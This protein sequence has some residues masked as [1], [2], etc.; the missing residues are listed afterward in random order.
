MT[1]HLKGSNDSICLVPI[2]CILFLKK[3]KESGLG[4]TYLSFSYEW[5]AKG[6]VMSIVNHKYLSSSLFFLLSSN[7]N[8]KNSHH[9]SN[10]NC[11]DLFRDTVYKHTFFHLKLATNKKLNHLI[12]ITVKKITPRQ[13]TFHSFIQHFFFRSVAARF[14]TY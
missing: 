13:I 7:N 14:K 9:R 8:K 4:P 2:Y 10:K 12:S 3:E 5:S 1:F 6:H 11:L